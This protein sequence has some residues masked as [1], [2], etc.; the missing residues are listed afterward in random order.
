[1]SRHRASSSASPARYAGWVPFLCVV[2][3]I[4]ALAGSAI[5]WVISPQWRH[6]GV[7]QAS[8]RNVGTVPVASG[9]DVAYISP[10]MIEIPRLGAR[11]PIVNVST[12]PGGALD[13]PLN[14]KIVGWWSG[15]AKPGAK[16]GTAVL[17][18]HINYAGVTGVLATINLLNPGD[19][20]Y[21]DGTHNGAKTR[22]KFTITGVRTYAKT[23]L[24]AKQIFDQHS[25]GRIAIVTCGGPFDAST[26]NYLDNIVAFAVP[27]A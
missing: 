5:T 14:P 6:P 25:V 13:V 17:D 8:A 2:A 20:V 15:G 4:V 24:P 23:A 16:R 1:M 22:L 18:G 12:L 21:I 3:A 27:A 10:N 11:A 7:T 19:V 26:G 9:V